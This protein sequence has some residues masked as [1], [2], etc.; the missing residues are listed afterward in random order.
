MINLLY[1]KI[2]NKLLPTLYNNNISIVG[3]LDEDFH[4]VKQF[5]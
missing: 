4:Y 1:I 5:I 2:L 3:N